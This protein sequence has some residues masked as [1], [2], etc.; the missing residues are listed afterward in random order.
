MYNWEDRVANDPQLLIL[1]SSRRMSNVPGVCLHM[2][3]MSPSPHL[4]Y[5][6]GEQAGLPLVLSCGECPNII[7]RIS[8]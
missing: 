4:L 2:K 3:E 8:I 5:N 6:H 1:R 7:T